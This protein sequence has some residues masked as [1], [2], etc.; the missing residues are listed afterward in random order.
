MM[1]SRSPILVGLQVVKIAYGQELF[2]FLLE[3]GRV[4]TCGT[5]YDGQLGLGLTHGHWHPCAREQC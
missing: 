3:A 2:V 4:F 1:R 5:Y